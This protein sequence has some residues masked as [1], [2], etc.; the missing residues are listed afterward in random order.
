[1]ALLHVHFQHNKLHLRQFLRGPNYELIQ[2]SIHYFGN[3]GGV[4]ERRI[5]GEGCVPVAL[6]LQRSA[7]GWCDAYK[8][9]VGILQIPQM[10]RKITS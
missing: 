8:K 3:G 5:G 10:A 9:T 2:A 6:T 1:M 4:Q 7:I